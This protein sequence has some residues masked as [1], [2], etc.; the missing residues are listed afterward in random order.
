MSTLITSD[1]WD[2]IKN[3]LIENHSILTDKNLTY[4]EGKE[5]KLLATLQRKLGKSKKEVS[6]MIR[7]YTK[8]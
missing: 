5:E 8:H 2:E 6:A 1:N 7:G 4:E 3:K